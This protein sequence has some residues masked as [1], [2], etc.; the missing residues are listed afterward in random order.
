MPRV[1]IITPT[2][3]QA[4][5]L[6]ETMD[7][8]LQQTFQD[9]EHIII[10]DGSTDNTRRIVEEYQKKYPS[11]IKYIAQKNAGPACARNRGI[12]EAKGEYIAF[13]DSDDLWAPTRLEEGVKILD[14]QPTIVLV[15]G[16]IIRIDEDGK[17]L[18]KLNRNPAGLSGHIFK[19]LLL[20]K[21]HIACLTVLAR[22][23]SLIEVGGFDEKIGNVAE[24]RD[25]WLRMTKNYPV[26]FVQ[27]HLGSYRVRTN[28]L[29]S[30]IEKTI[31]GNQK[32]I[33]K[34]CNGK[35]FLRHQALARLHKEAGDGFLLQT[36]F[37]EARRQYWQAIKSWPFYIWPWINLGK[38]FLR[39]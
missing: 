25:L 35:A 14:A 34:A 2:F 5:F 17:I 15:H 36:H 16:E 18:K 6:P 10:D 12:E 33:E 32:A 37:K 23:D 28:S 20:R 22:R 1:S 31:S 3:N 8:V 30:S 19:S 11:K 24:D 29:S 13:L 9:F 26:T 21:A 4:K 7:S 27:K 38:T 39:G